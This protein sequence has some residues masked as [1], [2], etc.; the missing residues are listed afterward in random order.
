MEDVSRGDRQH[1]HRQKDLGARPHRQEERQGEQQIERH[2]VVQR[3][4]DEK[5]RIVVAERRMQD[6]EKEHGAGEVVEVEL[7]GVQQGWREHGNACERERE[8]PV[9]RRDPLE[10]FQEEPGGRIGAAAGCDPHDEAADHE[11]DVD[12]G[13]AYAEI[14]EGEGVAQPARGIR[15]VEQDDHQGRDSAQI[16]EINDHRAP[17]RYTTQLLV[18]ACSPERIN[19]RIDSVFKSARNSSTPAG[20]PADHSRSVEFSRAA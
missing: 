6:G 15:H 17:R 19:V 3:P 14:R 9:K 18:A 20:A 10:A 7:R 5:Y 1:D 8:D 12:A 2:F 13:L 16:L 4:A 11:E